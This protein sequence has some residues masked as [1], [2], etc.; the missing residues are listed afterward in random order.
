MIL[1]IDNYD[2]VVYNLAR[3]FERLQQVTCVVRNDAIDV[4]KIALLQ[5]LAIV[6]SPGPGTPETAGCSLNV[7]RQFAGEIPLLGVCLGHQT[8]FQAFGGRVVRADQ[9]M[10]GRAS[11]VFHDKSALFEGLPN[12]FM[13]GRYHS[14]VAEEATL[15]SDLAI[16]ARTDDGVIMGLE[17]RAFRVYGVQFHPESILTQE[18]YPLLR[19]FLRLAGI[20]CVTAPHLSEE[21]IEPAERRDWKP[22]TPVTY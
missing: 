10:H 19:N 12:P 1:L 17:H 11:A 13:A 15:P 8:I 20:S 21:L 3:Y 18:G 6:L 5:P 4:K 2:I 14:L 9:P 7:V 22:R 16:T